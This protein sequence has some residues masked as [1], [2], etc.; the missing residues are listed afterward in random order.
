MDSKIESLICGLIKVNKYSDLQRRAARIH[1]CL[2]VL[3]ARTAGEPDPVIL[4]DIESFAHQQN[5]INKALDGEDVKVKN[6]QKKY[7]CLWDVMEEILSPYLRKHNLSALQIEMTIHFLNHLTIKR[8]SETMFTSERNVGYHRNEI[9]RK[10]NK[11]TFQE[12]IDE[13]WEIFSMSFTLV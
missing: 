1:S 10:M 6:M 8:V 13:L 9:T 11:E 3:S 12:V 4:D 7:S 2:E 5:S